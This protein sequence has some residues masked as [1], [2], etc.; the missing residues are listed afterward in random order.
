MSMFASSKL[1]VVS[2]WILAA[3]IIFAFNISSTIAQTRSVAPV[4][5]PEKPAR[6]AAAPA[7]KLSTKRRPVPNRES[8]N[9]ICGPITCPSAA[10]GKANL[11]GQLVDIEDSTRIDLGGGALCDPNYPTANGACSLGL[12][13]FDLFEFANNPSTATQLPYDQLNINACGFFAAEGITVPSS[14]FIGVSVDDADAVDDHS[15][16]AAGMHVSGGERID[17]LIVYASRKSTIQAW[18]NAVGYSNVA[19]NGVYFSLYYHRGEP[20]SGVMV[21]PSI[22]LDTANDYYFND[23][24][25]ANRLHVEPSF[26]NSTGINGAALLFEANLE[27]HSGMRYGNNPSHTNIG[28][29]EWPSLLAVSIPGVVFTQQFH[30]VDPNTGERCTGQ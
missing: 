25:P 5:A 1:H 23:N 17:E 4:R 15:P 11:C 24:D 19:N 7:N 27:N 18:S 12:Q 26:S 21:T 8:A 10:P 13:F 20:A 29:C 3:I 28:T 6:P 16:T 30:T 14:G 22:G 2:L 9:A